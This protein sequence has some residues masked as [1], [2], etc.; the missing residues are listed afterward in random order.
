MPPEV[1]LLS[2]E[3]LCLRR[4]DGTMVLREVSLALAAGEVL[5]V[6]GESGSGKTQLLLSLVGLAMPGAVLSGSA[7]FA[8]QQ[9]VGASEPALRALRGRRI[10]MLFQD[11][12]S[13]LN[14]CLSI[15]AQ[16]AEVLPERRG[17]GRAAVRER[18]L[19]ALRAVDMPDPGHVLRQYPHE[20]SG[21]M[22]QRVMLAMAVLAEPDLLLADEP[23]T[24]L[25]VTTQAKVLDLMRS[26]GE[27]LGMAILL[28]TH[29]LGV[30]ARM[31][32]RALV[33]RQGEVVEQGDTAT[34]LTRPRSPYG[35]E[36][37]AAVRRLETPRGA[38]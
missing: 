6:V 23:T 29:D 21:G 34:L 37:L 17:Q 27:R 15:R 10:A 5:A 26:L 3:R 28:V 9:L 20:L 30:V 32:P 38:P 36:L 1:P 14:P 16:L 18:L 7:R 8:G 24:A 4:A 33:L 13:A 25:D 22:R 11:P 2:L 19:A 31:A 35:A 12:R